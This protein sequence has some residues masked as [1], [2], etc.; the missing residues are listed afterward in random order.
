MVIEFASAFF[1]KRIRHLV[2]PGFLLFFDPVPK[3]VP[4]RVP[5]DPSRCR[6][7]S[8]L[9]PVLDRNKATDGCVPPGVRFNRH[10]IFNMNVYV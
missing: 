10:P 9:G 3:R 8:V 7:S 5:Y 1:G 2:I 4:D 6:D